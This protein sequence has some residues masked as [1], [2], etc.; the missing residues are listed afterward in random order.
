MKSEQL[1]RAEIAFSRMRLRLRSYQTVAITK[2]IFEYSES[3]CEKQPEEARFESG[4]LISKSV[5][6]RIGNVKK[7]ISVLMLGIQFTHCPTKYTVT[8]LK[9]RKYKIKIIQGQ[10]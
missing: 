8:Y 9:D 6:P 7:T 10:E 1:T 3:G 2:G 5:F 4:R